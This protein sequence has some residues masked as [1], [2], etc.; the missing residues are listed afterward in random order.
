MGGGK[1][2]GVEKVPKAR[3]LDISNNEWYQETQGEHEQIKGAK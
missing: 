2:S 3:I 1:R